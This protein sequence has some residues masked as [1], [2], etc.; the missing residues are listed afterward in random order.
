MALGAELIAL[1]KTCAE[2]INRNLKL[3]GHE[4]RVDHRSNEARGL[5]SP[6][7]RH[8]GPAAVRQRQESRRA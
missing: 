3:H 7:G 5:T 8:L 1:R 4:A 2:T 6:P